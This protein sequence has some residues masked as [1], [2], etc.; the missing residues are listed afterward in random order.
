M[1]SI[2]FG[3]KFSYLPII[4]QYFSSNKLSLTLTAKFLKDRLD[5]YCHTTPEQ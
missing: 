1:D 3:N 5:V 4:S 2:A